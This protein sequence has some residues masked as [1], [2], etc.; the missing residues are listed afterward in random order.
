MENYVYARSYASLPVVRNVVLSKTC[1]IVIATTVSA[2]TTTTTTAT[3]TTATSVPPT[4]PEPTFV[5]RYNGNKNDFLQPEEYLFYLKYR[6]IVKK[7]SIFKTRYNGM[8]GQR[9]FFFLGELAVLLLHFTLCRYTIHFF[10]SHGCKC[11]FNR[12]RFC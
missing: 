1:R 6:K 5:P 11:V 2:T 10:S 8:K 3:T 4:A 9:F 12:V 7:R